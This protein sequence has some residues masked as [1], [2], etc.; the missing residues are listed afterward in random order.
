MSYCVWVAPPNPFLLIIS[1]RIAS[2]VMVAGCPPTE[3]LAES[4]IKGLHAAAPV[5]AADPVMH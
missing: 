1:Q 2:F 3:E 4:T 5:M